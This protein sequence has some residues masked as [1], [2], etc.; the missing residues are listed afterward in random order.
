MYLYPTNLTAKATLWLWE[1][2]DIAIIGAGL[3]AGVFAAVQLG[4]LFPLV[5]VAVYA[6][7]VVQADGMSILRFLHRA[8]AFLLFAPQRYDWRASCVF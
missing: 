5:A 3:L 2:R 8:A 6:F 7:L 4:F 1:V